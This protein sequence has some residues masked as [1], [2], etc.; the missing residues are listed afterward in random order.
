LDKTE[1]TQKVDFSLFETLNIVIMSFAYIA[2]FFSAF[3]VQNPSY[4]QYIGIL[5]WLMWLFGLILA[6][7]PNYVFKK[8]GGVPKGKSYVHT[9]KLVDEGIYGIIRHPQYTGGIVIV[10]SMCLILQTLVAYFLAALAI[11]TSYL[12]MIFEEKRLNTKFGSE[13]ENY[14]AK[15]PRA[16]IILGLIR[17][18][19][20]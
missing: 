4:N 20:K 9:T 8:H 14:Q 12:S 10:I 11:T 19:R 5:G 17:K 15:V 7:S 13:Y 2:L 6:F 1:E 16:N 18:L 3:I